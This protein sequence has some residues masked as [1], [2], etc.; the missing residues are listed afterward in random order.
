MGVPGD[1]SK[2]RPHLASPSGNPAS[3]GGGKVRHRLIERSPPSQR[4]SERVGHGAHV[5][6]PGP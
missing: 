2:E 3:A 4:A 6:G 5:V 1:P